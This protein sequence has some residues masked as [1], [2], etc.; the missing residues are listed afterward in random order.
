MNTSIF[1]LSTFETG[2]YVDF[3]KVACIVGDG[4][5]SYICLADGQRILVSKCLE[6]LE[7]RLPQGKFL[8][9]HKRH[10]VNLDF[11]ECIFSKQIKLTDGQVYCVAR[12]RWPKI[13]S[14]FKK[15]T[16]TQLS[17]VSVSAQI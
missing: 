16:A 9:V 8:R 12:R 14:Y 2:E 5:Y 1:R 3:E 10:M 6:Q 15:K 13:H 7:Q 11:V 17:S 4:N